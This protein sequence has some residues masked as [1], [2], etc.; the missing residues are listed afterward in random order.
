MSV[1]YSTNKGFRNF[2]VEKK[3]KNLVSV[4]WT[5]SSP[6]VCFIVFPRRE[7]LFGMILQQCLFSWWFWGAFGEF[8]VLFWGSF[9][10]CLRGFLI[11]FSWFSKKSDKNYLFCCIKNSYSSYLAILFDL[12]E[13]NRHIGLLNSVKNTQK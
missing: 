7:K 10:V 2:F 4:E 12:E 11:F 1:F 8:L 13:V 5:R 9:F 6:Q 3:P